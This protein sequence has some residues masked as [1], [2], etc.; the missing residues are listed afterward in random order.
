MLRPA[1]RLG[2]HH[3]ALSVIPLSKPCQFVHAAYAKQLAKLAAEFGVKPAGQPFLHV[4]MATVFLLEGVRRYLAPNGVFACVLPDAIMNG[5]HQNRFRSGAYTSASRAV[6]LAFD[7]IWKIEG[8]TFKN[9]A[10]VLLGGKSLSHPQST[11]GGLLIGERG[12]TA[13]TFHINVAT[14]AGRSDRVIWSTTP[15]VGPV[16]FGH[17]PAPFRQGADL[18]PRTAWFHDLNGGPN[19]RFA[20]SPAAADPL[21]RYLV[22]QGKKAKNFVLPPLNVDGDFVFQALLSN[23]LLP[24]HVANRARCLLPFL[25]DAGGWEALLEQKLALRG[26]GTIRAF[27]A[28]AAGLGVSVDELSGIVNVRNKLTAPL[29]LEGAYIVVSGA[30]GTTPC[31]AYLTP[32]DAVP[33]SLVFD[34]TV[35]WAPV[36]S[37]KEAIYLT[38]AIN[39]P[40]CA[41]MI[42]PFQPMGAQGPR[43]VHELPFGVTPRFNPDD[44]AHLRL[45]AATEALMNDLD[46]LATADAKVLA[47]RQPHTGELS[48]RRP[49]I[50]NAAQRT[51]AWAEYA[52]AAEAVYLL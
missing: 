5:D 19:G 13:Q 46:E 1:N 18:M 32:A 40:T 39:S 14:Y 30:G 9:E 51:N 10:V 36:E 41:A 20:A 6:T 2:W 52:E 28:I 8:A 29:W 21:L 37:R 35:Y 42:R 11:F 48:R 17:N 33:G 44:S 50:S 24:F 25:Y 38:G 47:A 45:V 49:A 16:F 12:S 31:A 27:H 22:A 34:Q 23:Q 4:E 26:A 7:G 43:H 15:S 3:V